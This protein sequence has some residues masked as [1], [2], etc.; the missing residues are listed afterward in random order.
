MVRQPD[1]ATA[2]NLLRTELA[3]DGHRLGHQKALD[4]TARLFG[5][6]NLAHYRATI[7][8]AP[9]VAEAVGLP[10]GLTQA[11]FDRAVKRLA[12][13]APQG[14]DPRFPRS[15]WVRDTEN[16]LDYWP[17]V[18]TRMA[19][20]G[21]DIT[22][23]EVTALG[24]TVFHTLDNLYYWTTQAT[25]QI[26]LCPGS[27]GVDWDGP[28]SG[29]EAARRDLTSTYPAA[30]VTL[31]DRP[32]SCEAL[33]FPLDEPSLRVTLEVEVGAPAD[34]A[35]QELNAL[36]AQ[37]RVHPE[38]PDGRNPLVRW[39]VMR[40]VDRHRYPSPQFG[41]VQRVFH[42]ELRLTLPRGFDATKRAQV[43]SL[44]YYVELPVLET[45]LKAQVLGPE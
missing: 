29:E 15:E 41:Q 5:Y 2:A 32:V 24:A 43:D 10:A 11:D 13:P 12:G 35:T 30:R 26:P 1:I 7:P 38:A 22:A 42:V 6:K 8:E 20:V 16:R 9:T 3:K 44:K 4:L 19:Q 39:N 36:C 25:D 18:A 31:L 28:Y 33:G 21:E 14:S 27:E 34:L 45:R 23:L 37:M 40:L 17:W